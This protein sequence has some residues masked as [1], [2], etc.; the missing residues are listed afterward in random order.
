[1]RLGLVFNLFFRSSKVQRKRAAL[2]V[3]GIAWGTVSIVLLLAFGQGLFVQMNK[4][5]RGMG[6]NLA[7]LWMGQ[8]SKPYKGLPEGRP[9]RTRI[10]DIDLL[11][12]RVTDL[13]G[14][15]G[16]IQQWGVNI[17]Y[18]GQTRNTHVRGV[19]PCYGD[20]RNQIPEPG[21][22]FLDPLDFKKKR[23]VIFLG[24]ELAHDLFGDEPAVGKEVLLDQTPY[25]VIGVLVKKL[26]M[27]NYGGMDADHVVIPISTFQGQ[28]GRDELSVIVAKPPVAAHMERMLL[29]IRQ[30]LGGKYAF[31]PDDEKVFGVWNTVEG[32]KVVSNILIGLEV[33]LGIIGA[34][35]LLIGGIGV[36]N[37]MYAVVKE[38]TREI[39]VKMA[40]G[41]RRS[42]ITGPIV[43]ESLAFT[44]IGGLIGLCIAGLIVG[45]L[46]LAPTEGNRALE[47]LGVP[48]LSLPIGIATA[49][50]LGLIGLVAGY[51]PARRAASID[52]AETLRYE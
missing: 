1:M 49:S 35:T 8:T 10:E 47:M 23:R 34:M 32:T 15:S 33:F 12:E 37:I 11:R 24:D 38:R 5:K 50:I 20:L 26:M 42:W 17:S 40:L 9:I 18:G 30:V 13:A 6:E 27:G 39:G 46:S 51:F 52:P 43:L 3:A 29:Q 19:H 41:A 16:E 44:M 22:R 21:G 2:T 25:L 45:L 31:D 7:V 28:F 36:G 14:V 4:N 48:I